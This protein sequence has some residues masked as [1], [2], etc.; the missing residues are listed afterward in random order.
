MYPAW[1]ESLDSNLDSKSSGHGASRY[2]KSFPRIRSYLMDG[3]RAVPAKSAKNSWP[4]LFGPRGGAPNFD[5]RVEH[6]ESIQ[7]V[8]R[9][10]LYKPLVWLGSHENQQ[11]MPMLLADTQ[12]MSLQ[13]TEVFGALACAE[14]LANW[15]PHFRRGRASALQKSAREV[16]TPREEC[17]DSTNCV[18]TI[19]SQCDAIR[20]M[21]GWGA[22]L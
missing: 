10:T 16:N 9:N 7:C 15:L 21:V 1:F 14:N 5:R 3:F 19:P 18:G 2:M 20:A 4:G 6:Q 13:S 8:R 22:S 12:T 17:D 11:T